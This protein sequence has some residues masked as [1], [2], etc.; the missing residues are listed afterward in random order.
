MLAVQ[1]KRRDAFAK[2]GVSTARSTAAQ[3]V[4][5]WFLIV[6]AGCAVE[7]VVETPAFANASRAMHSEM[8]A[9]GKAL[10]AHLNGLETRPTAAS[11]NFGCAMAANASAPCFAGLHARSKLP[12]FCTV[13]CRFARTLCLHARSARTHIGGNSPRM[14][15]NGRSWHDTS[16]SDTGH[17]FDWRQQLSRRLNRWQQFS[18]WAGR[19]WQFSTF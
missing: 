9:T 15:Y 13:L 12:R 3:A 17:N 1:S 8:W 11:I 18:R 7:R 16:W 2:A 19:W 14:A 10:Y 4:R 6:F 5:L